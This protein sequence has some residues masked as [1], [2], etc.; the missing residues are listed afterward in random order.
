MSWFGRSRDGNRQTGGP[1]GAAPQVNLDELDAYSRTVVSVVQRV[2][3]AVVQIGV[4]REVR[5]PGYAGLAPR[6]AEG[7]GSGVIFA[8]DGY[9]LTN[10][11]VVDRAHRIVVTLADGQDL[12]GSL[13]GEDPETDTAVVRV[14]P[15]DG[16]KLPAATLGDSEQLQVG[17]LVVAI[18][19][20]A[21][22]QST[23]TTGIVSA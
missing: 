17:Q 7:A 4:L 20:P 9:I 16:Q 11:H 12:P 14:S 5:A 8:P 1:R 15:P 18:G 6:L 13:V 23:V 22:L 2:G 19:S 3:P 10:S 21:G